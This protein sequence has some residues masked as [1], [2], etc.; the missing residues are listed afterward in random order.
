[1]ASGDLSFVGFSSQFFLVFFKKLSYL[2]SVFSE[3]YKKKPDLM[4][5]N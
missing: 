5:E 3:V 1:M 4:V 2:G